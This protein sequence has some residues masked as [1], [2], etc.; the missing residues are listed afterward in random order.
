M[1]VTPPAAAV[2]GI[3]IEV[4]AVVELFV[5]LRDPE[6]DAEAEPLAVTEVPDWAGAAMMYYPQVPGMLMMCDAK[7]R[8]GGRR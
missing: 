1:T 8:T 4:V 5:A 6:A 3:E 2:A 7:R